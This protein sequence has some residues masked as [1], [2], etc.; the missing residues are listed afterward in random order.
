MHI[1]IRKIY[2][3]EK[4]HMN[5]LLLP[6]G[7][8]LYLV[9]FFQKALG[10]RGEVH[11]SNTELSPA[12]FAADKYFLTPPMYSADY[13]DVILQYCIE[14]AVHAVIPLS[15]L[16]LPVLSLAKSEFLSHGIKIIVADYHIVDICN[17]KWQS[18]QF[19]K[20][21]NVN[22][23]ATFLTKDDFL[24]SVRKGLSTF[25]VMVKLRFGAGAFGVY[26]A[27]NESEI[28]LYMSVSEKLLKK[29]Y[30]KNSIPTNMQPLALLQEKIQGYE[31]TLDVVNDLAG[32]YRT[33][34]IKKKLGILNGEANPVVFEDVEIIK[35]L[36]K[37]IGEALKHVGDCNVDCILS[38][39]Q[40]YVLDLNPRFGGCYPYSQLAGANLP[41]A[42]VAW[43]HGEEPE[44]SDLT[45][46]TGTY[47]YKENV[48]KIGRMV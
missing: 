24:Q 25:P 6:T 4:A 43:L 37:Q 48:A 22:T 21:K 47:C 28:D 18:Y 35:T 46:R 30:L 31:Y 29:S 5:I 3:N 19:M 2:Y 14:H 23:P 12:L 32:N 34:F 13:K 15:D 38:G 27:E 26:E 45:V 16:N 20:S 11:A 8:R 1:I 41:R 33:T 9:E 36:G 44:T 40:V 42:I 39:E 10:G 7:K 17:D